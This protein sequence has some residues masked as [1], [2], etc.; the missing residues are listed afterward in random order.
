[1]PILNV[2]MMTSDRVDLKLRNSIVHMR[3]E[4]F[5]GSLLLYP[6]EVHNIVLF[7]PAR[8]GKSTTNNNFAISLSEINDPP[9]RTGSGDEHVTL[10]FTKYEL[11]NAKNVIMPV[12]INLFETYGF[13]KETYSGNEVE[14]ILD[15]RMKLGVDYKEAPKGKLKKPVEENRIDSVA[16]L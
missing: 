16:L 10:T 5:A 9:F 3:S 13:E 14:W 4:A 7:G 2:T 11:K 15:G 8:S 12:N 6:N 1:P